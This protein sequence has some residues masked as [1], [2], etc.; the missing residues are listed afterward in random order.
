MSYLLWN[1][2]EDKDLQ[3][4]AS[5]SRPGPGRGN[6]KPLF[7]SPRPG[8]EANVDFSVVIKFY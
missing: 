6:G 2:H 1:E 7:P 4:L 3:D 5:R 8:L